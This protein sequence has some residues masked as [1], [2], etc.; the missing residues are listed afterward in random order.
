MLTPQKK[1]KKKKKKKKNAKIPD[2]VQGNASHMLK[3]LI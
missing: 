1:K 2:V 3:F